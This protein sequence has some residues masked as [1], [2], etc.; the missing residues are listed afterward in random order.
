MTQHIRQL[1]PP[2]GWAC[3]LYQETDPYFEVHELLYWALCRH[4]IDSSSV[5]GLVALDQVVS[6][7]ELDNFACYVH[8][9]MINSTPESFAMM[10]Q[11]VKDGREYAKRQ[12]EKRKFNAAVARPINSFPD[13]SAQTIDW[14]RI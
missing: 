13:I 5:Q 11:W 8:R 9:D 7:E 1:L 3:V 6:A 4:D 2:D 12:R 14:S 10:Q